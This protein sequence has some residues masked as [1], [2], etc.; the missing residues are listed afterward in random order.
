MGWACGKN[1]GYK[2]YVENLTEE[3][4]LNTATWKPEN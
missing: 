1:G 4:S 3:I 2:E